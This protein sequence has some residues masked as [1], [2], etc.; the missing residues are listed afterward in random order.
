MDEVNEISSSTTFLHEEL[1]NGSVAFLVQS[2]RAS[3]LVNI[4]DAAHAVA[5]AVGAQAQHES[6]ASG[7]QHAS[8]SS[9]QQGGGVMC[10]QALLNVL[11]QLFA[12]LTRAHASVGDEWRA[13]EHA[14]TN[15]LLK[16]IL[17]SSSRQ[18]QMKDALST[19]IQ[20]LLHAA[21][22]QLRVIEQVQHQVHFTGV[23][24]VTVIPS[25]SP[26]TSLFDDYIW[27]AV[28][29]LLQLGPEG[30]KS[31]FEGLRKGS[32]NA[33]DDVFVHHLLHM[34]LRLLGYYAG[35]LCDA[36][37]SFGLQ[38]TTV[39]DQL[40]RQTASF[41]IEA[42][43]IFSGTKPVSHEARRAFSAPPEF[44]QI[45]ERITGTAASVLGL[46]DNV[47]LV[48]VLVDSIESF[49]ATITWMCAVVTFCTWK[50]A[51]DE[52]RG[53][54]S[55][56]MLDVCIRIN[57]SSLPLL[58]HGA[59][60]G[61]P[62]HHR[63]TALLET[64][65]YRMLV[66]SF[67]TIAA[68][69]IHRAQALDLVSSSST[70]SPSQSVADVVVVQSPDVLCGELLQQASRM[71]EAVGG[72]TDGG[73]LRFSSLVARALDEV[74][75]FAA[76]GEENFL[77]TD[78]STAFAA[79]AQLFSQFEHDGR[80]SFAPTGGNSRHAASVAAELQLGS[81]LISS[82]AGAVLADHNKDASAHDAWWQ[83]CTQ[84]WK[85]F[86]GAEAAS[87]ARDGTIVRPQ[88]VAVRSES[89]ALEDAVDVLAPSWDNIQSWEHSTRRNGASKRPVLDLPPLLNAAARSLNRTILSSLEVK[90]GLVKAASYARVFAQL[91]LMNDIVPVEVPAELLQSASHV[92]AAAVDK[93][94]PDAVNERLLLESLTAKVVASRL[95]VFPV[96]DLRE[97]ASAV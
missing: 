57:A 23:P 76:V 75:Q 44:V 25:Q 9:T 13:A 31:K 46:I 51:A 90:G 39:I 59:L 70:S 84:Y 16:M 67:V 71:I 88:S 27:L 45:V 26:F 12:F 68:W 89:S 14:V 37:G 81:H 3:D 38:S 60:D 64:L 96:C 73:Q 43:K 53:A 5:S 86:S 35:R 2:I 6:T 50:A 91:L 92:L 87:A 4:R 32:K 36:H 54:I 1:V 79:I 61:I 41:P 65:A 66:S 33:L 63:S 55:R 17:L 10:P 52:H 95:R 48:P 49:R 8:A 19:H 28:F 15:L 56:R 82:F 83:V 72:G 62:N 47:L 42:L 94:Y 22:V 11:T 77:V 58:R 97:D 69:S 29:S 85:L 30:L 20:F 80:R 40:K 21:F 24:S 7:S 78:H 34:T 74:S 93:K 18:S